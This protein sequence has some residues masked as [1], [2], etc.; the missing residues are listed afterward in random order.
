NCPGALTCGGAAACIAGDGWATSGGEFLRGAG[1]AGVAG[2]GACASAGGCW[3]P[4][5]P[6]DGPCGCAGGPCTVG[7]AFGRGKPC[8]GSVAGRFGWASAA[9]PAPG[10][11]VKAG[12]GAAPG[13]AGRPCAPGATSAG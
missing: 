12:P 13:T 2:C 7:I 4:G 10:W 9:T 8:A 1:S 6:G 11:G 5:C 3:E